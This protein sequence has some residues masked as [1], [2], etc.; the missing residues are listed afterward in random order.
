[1]DDR[2]QAEVLFTA[3]VTAAEVGDDDSALAAVE[4]INRLE[5]RIDDPYLESTLQLAVSWTLPI[6]DDF[7]GALRAASTALA[8]FRQQNDPFVAFA[9][10][11]VGMLE[12]TLGRDDTARD[13]LTEVNEL[14]GQFGNNWLQ[15]SA[16][17]QLATLAVRTGQLDDARALLAKSVDAIED[18]PLS[19]LTVTFALVAF[20]QL[21]VAEA[22]TRGAAHSNR[23][24]RRAAKTCRRAGVAD[25]A[26]K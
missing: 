21:A 9:A 25:N 14:G 23:C 4:E 3:A 5:G 26:T 11:T 13:Y 19:T 2:A 8:G 22:D 10:L 20:A 6:V 12:M 16:R 18:A 17:T 24:R 1:M 7:D 15:S